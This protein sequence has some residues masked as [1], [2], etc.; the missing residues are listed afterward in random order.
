MPVFGVTEWIIVAAVVSLVA[1]WIKLLDSREDNWRLL[2]FCGLLAYFLPLV[3]LRNECAKNKVLRS[4][5][6][7]RCT[8][9]GSINL[10]SRYR[11]LTSGMCA[12]HS[13]AA[14]QTPA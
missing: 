4:I 12:G 14:G 10:Y 3:G 1:V 5:C 7:K 9:P 11:S 2:V 13:L 6:V 8:S